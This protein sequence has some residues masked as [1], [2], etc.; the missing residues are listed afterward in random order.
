VH[1]YFGVT[2]EANV[3]AYFEGQIDDYE[4][5]RRDIAIWK[6]F[7][8]DICLED[9]RKILENIPPVPGAI[10][11]LKSLRAQNMIIA[12][13]SGGLEVLAQRFS[14]FVSI[15]HIFAN[16]LS[17]DG[18]GRLKDEGIL[19][20]PLRH[21][22]KVLLEL[23]NELPIPQERCVAVGDSTVDAGML[24]ASGLGIAFC[25]LDD[26]VTQSADVVI[27]EKNLQEI[28]KYI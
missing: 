19:N 20:V 5:M 15:D 3:K 16:R 12:I 10:D 28:L 9:V 13:I 22:E 25:P 8:P 14:E 21:K 7:K 2:N 17:N 4:F 24:K 6:S 18:S 26:I 11:T 27:K 1:E 23:L